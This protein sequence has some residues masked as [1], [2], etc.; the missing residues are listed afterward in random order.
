MTTLLGRR[1]E[2]LRRV[3]RANSDERAVRHPLGLAVADR[4]TRQRWHLDLAHPAATH[5]ALGAALLDGWHR[6]VDRSRTE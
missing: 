6:A 1:T 3:E 2:A 4:T 5:A